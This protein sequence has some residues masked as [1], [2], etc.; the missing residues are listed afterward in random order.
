MKRKQ[1]Y[2]PIFG[3]AWAERT[4]LLPAMVRGHYLD[5]VLWSWNHPGEKI[6]KQTDAQ[7]QMARSTNPREW[8]SVWT[9]VARLLTEHQDGYSDPWVEAI[10]SE[11][12]N[13]KALKSKA[14]QQS[15]NA[16]AAQREQNNQQAGQQSGNIRATNAQQSSQQNGNP[17]TKY[18]QEQEVQGGDPPAHWREA[19]MRDKPNVRVLI[20]LAHDVLS[21]DRLARDEGG[22]LQW[23]FDELKA[24]A[25][26]LRIAYDSTSVEKAVAGA[27][28][29]QINGKRPAGPTPSDSPS[30][31]AAWL[32]SE[33]INL[34]GGRMPREALTPVVYEAAKM[35]WADNPAL[36][37][38][39]IQ[40][41]WSPDFFRMFPGFFFVDGDTIATIP[42]SPGVKK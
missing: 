3:N 22:S 38:R 5:I 29:Q 1:T 27:R 42:L 28:W 33:L 39:V 9:I 23:A 7:M 6:P 31:L 21:N 32:V 18:Q 26:Q 12:A 13:Y 37:E 14:G 35:Q 15:A 36:A 40:L 20:R 30:E 25:A 4:A 41:V 8:R 16:R 34:H 17:S 10:R 19:W 2:F 24:R 11:D